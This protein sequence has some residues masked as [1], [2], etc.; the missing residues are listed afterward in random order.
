MNDIP[1]SKDKLNKA[2]QLART[3]IQSKLTLLLIMGILLFGML[4]L[5]LTPRTYNPEIIVPA[6]T[7]SVSRPGSD[8]QEMLNQIELLISYTYIFFNC[9]I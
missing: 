1:Y 8:T 3:F 4:A 5:E 9:T 6:V 7:L 2:G